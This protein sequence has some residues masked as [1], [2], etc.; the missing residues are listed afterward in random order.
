M[1]KNK[2]IDI[3]EILD[4]VEFTYKINENNTVSLVDQ[5]GANLGNIESDE[6]T[7]KDNLAIALIDRLSIYIEDYITDYYANTLIEECQEHADKSDSYL[8]L[9]NKMKKYPKVFDEDC[10]NLIKALDNPN[11]F[12]DVSAI[13]NSSKL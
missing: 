1:N 9:L 13:I 10:L 12:I 4:T 5:L 11:E 3:L 2:K 7:I 6:F 8:D